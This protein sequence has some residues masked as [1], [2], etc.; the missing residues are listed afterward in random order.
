MVC[1]ITIKSLSPSIHNIQ[2]Q[3]RVV[4]E[5]LNGTSAKLYVLVVAYTQFQFFKTAVSQGEVMA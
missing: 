4:K 1:N 5:A 3:A 2:K